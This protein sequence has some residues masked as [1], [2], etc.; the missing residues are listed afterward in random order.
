M[1]DPI[2]KRIRIVLEQDCSFK[3]QEEFQQYLETGCPFFF[4]GN[5]PKMNFATPDLT[6]F[7]EIEKHG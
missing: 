1:C 6:E 4:G 3:S 2:K 7:S 5:T